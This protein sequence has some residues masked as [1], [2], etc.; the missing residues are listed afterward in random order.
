[1]CTVPW[2]RMCHTT[3]DLPLMVAPCHGCQNPIAPYVL[4]SGV[5]LLSCIVVMIGCLT[6]PGGRIF[7]SA[8]S[9]L[10]CLVVSLI[11][12][13]LSIFGI[14]MIP[15]DLLL[16]DGLKPPSKL[17][18]FILSL[19]RLFRGKRQHVSSCFNFQPCAGNDD[20]CMSH[21][22]CVYI[23]IIMYIWMDHWTTILIHFWWFVALTQF[24]RF[25]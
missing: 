10:I 9:R 12:C 25:Y 14:M 13:F 18:V 17:Q 8:F 5:S 3:Y 6:A 21:Y 24:E 15:T 7:G 1:M 2:T 22:I 11:R 23:Y 19:L 16:W 4:C 20:L